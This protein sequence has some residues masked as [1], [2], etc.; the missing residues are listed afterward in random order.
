M[1]V[2]A[3]PLDHDHGKKG[4]GEGALSLMEGVET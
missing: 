4:E 1:I 3:D 2:I